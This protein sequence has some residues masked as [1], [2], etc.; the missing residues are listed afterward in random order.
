MKRLL[1]YLS[2]ARDPQRFAVG[3]ALA[4]AAD[5]AGWSFDCY[6]GALRRGRHFGGGDPGR[7]RPGWPS[8]SL[9]SGGRHLEQAFQL[10]CRRDVVALGDPHCVLWPALDDAGAES[11]ARSA[12]PAVLYKAA[13]DRLG[14]DAPERVL[15]VDA[16]PQGKHAIIAAPY[17]YPAFFD[18]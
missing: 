9:V 6:Y 10:A 3:P 13:F 17:L 4:A 11:A 8:G 2:H 1:L 16:Q 14:V 15:V 18:R 5:R 7:A 12:D